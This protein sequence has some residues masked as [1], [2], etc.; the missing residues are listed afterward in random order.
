MCLKI[1]S[2]AAAAT[3]ISAAVGWPG[4]SSSGLLQMMLRKPAFLI[5]ATSS[6]AIWGETA[7]SSLME[8]YSTMSVLERFLAGT[9][10]TCRSTRQL[11]DALGCSRSQQRG[12]DRARDHDACDHGG[13]E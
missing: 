11:P 6:A 3:A 12:P 13:H 8:R 10:A 9:L 4:C 5:A 1:S 2:S 7:Y